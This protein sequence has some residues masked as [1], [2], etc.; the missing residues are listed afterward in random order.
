MRFTEVP[1]QAYFNS[2][3]LQAR[4]TILNEASASKYLD[5]N[6]AQA[7]TANDLKNSISMTTGV[8]TTIHHAGQPVTLQNGANTIA[9]CY[10]LRQ[11]HTATSDMATSSVSRTAQLHTHIMFPHAVTPTPPAPRPCPP[12][13]LPARR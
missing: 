3:F 13:A 4:N 2:G 8:K 5:A 9:Y 11:P 12:P 6:N 10:M 1:S 7:F